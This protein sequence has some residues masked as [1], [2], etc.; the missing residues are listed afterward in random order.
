M[1]SGE[2]KWITSPQS[3]QQ[4]QA[5][6]ARAGAIITGSGTVLADDPCLNVRSLPDLPA[7]M[8]L[9]DISQPLRVVLD[10]RGQLADQPQLQLFSQPQG[11]IICSDTPISLPAGVVHWPV[12]DLSALL[13]E[14]AARGQ[15]RSVL[16]EAGA[17]LATAFLQ[18]GLVDELI[19]YQAPVLL[20]TMAQPMTRLQFDQLSERLAFTLADV[21]PFGP[22]LRMVFRRS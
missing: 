19:I 15:V 2:S 16:V 4:V 13:Y 7:D 20:G 3:R 14:L 8:T 21:T 22:D 17:T 10:R 6:R 9:D 5:D 11:L 1:A 18:A 12:T